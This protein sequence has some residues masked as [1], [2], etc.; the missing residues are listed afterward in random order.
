MSEVAVQQ[1]MFPGDRKMRVNMFRSLS[2]FLGLISLAFAATVKGATITWG[3]PVAVDSNAPSQVLNGVTIG[4][5]FSAQNSIVAVNGIVFSTGLA[6]IT[7]ANGTQGSW[8]GQGPRTTDYSWLLAG[9]LYNQNDI[10]TT[11]S[12]LTVGKP[13][14]LQ[15]FTAFSGSGEEM[16][17]GNSSDYSSGSVLMGNTCTAPT[18]VIGTFTA[19]A[20]TQSFHW[21]RASGSGYTYMG[22]VQVREVGSVDTSAIVWDAPVA[23]NISDPSQ[24]VNNGT[25]VTAVSAM[26][27]AYAVNGVTFTNNGLGGLT[28]QASGTWAGG[29]LEPEYHGLFETA[30]WRYIQRQVRSGRHYLLRSH[31]WDDVQDSGLCRILRQ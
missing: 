30:R 11:L 19:D 17:L 4:Q 10:T 7:S 18:F 24:V 25:L 15:V 1:T 26:S 13:Y 23:V 27:T 20:T 28:T 16:Q 2:V 5:A 8:A 6:G 22:A 3:T 9:G 21:R 14:Q 29:E 31:P 12:G